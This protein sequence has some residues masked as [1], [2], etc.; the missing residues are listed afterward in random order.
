MLAQLSAT[1]SSPKFEILSGAATFIAATAYAVD[2]L[3]LPE[4]VTTVLQQT[5][6][7]ISIFFAVEYGLRLFCASDR[8]RYV[9]S[10][11]ALIDLVSFLPTTMALFMPGSTEITTLSGFRLLRILRLQR[12]LVDFDS[13]AKLELALGLPPSKLKLSQLQ[14]AR[15]FS[16]LGTLLY[17]ATGLIYDAE[18][19]ANPQIPDFFTALYFGL[20]TLTTV[21]FGDITPV[22]FNGRLVVCASILV[23]IGV[24]P[25]QLTELAESLLKGEED[26]SESGRLR[27]E[28]EKDEEELRLLR[29]SERMWRGRYELM[30]MEYVRLMKEKEGPDWNEAAALMFMEA[31][32]DDG[33]AASD[34][35]EEL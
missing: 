23:G 5:E 17:I 9:F 6:T 19:V 24:I 18:H 28:L 1:L 26:E 27:L 4:D 16:S 15:V 25:L 3:D 2:T 22:T 12:F 7:S 8:L 14:F 10:P 30:R 29:D 31:T 33:D 35:R 21:G 11:L 32:N 34:S 20:C 13:F